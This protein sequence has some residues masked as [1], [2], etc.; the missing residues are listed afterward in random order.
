MK[1]QIIDIPG[2][3]VQWPWSQL[4]LSGEKTIETR[5]YKLPEKYLNRELAI[6][7]TPGPNGFKHLGVSKA[8][9]IGTIVFTENYLYRSKLHWLE[10]LTLHRV[11]PDDPQYK[12]VSNK[13]KWAWKVGNVKSLKNPVPAPSKRGII[14]A[15]SCRFTNDIFV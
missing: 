2:L 4:L 8:R 11:N 6:I 5:N 9:I 13:P 15:S 3:N 1:V 10:E 12:F 7:E 14:F